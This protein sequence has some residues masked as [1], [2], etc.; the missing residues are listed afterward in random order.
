MPKKPLQPLEDRGPLRI[1]FALTSMPVGGAETLLMNLTQKFNRDRILPEICC[2]KEPG[3]L[4][5]KIKKDLPVHCN[6][7]R[8]KYDVTVAWKLARLFKQR[9]I[10][11]LVTVGAGDKM[12]WGRIAAKIAK[13]PVIACALHSTGWPDGVGRLNR[14]LT[15][16]TD[17]FIAVAKD[18]KRF[19]VEHERFPE[20]RI[21]FIPNGVDTE[22]FQDVSAFHDVRAEFGI[23]AAAP[24]VGLVAALRPEKNLTLFLDMAK[25]VS[26]HIPESHFLL[27]G[28]GPERTKLEQ[29]AKAIGVEKNVHF[30]GTRSDIPSILS[31]MNVFAL[32]SHNEANPVSILEAMST[33]LPIVATNVGSI[34]ESVAHEKTGFLVTP[35]CC[36]ELAGRVLNFL[37]NPVK[38]KAFGDRGRKV[39]QES[40]SLAAMVEGYEDLLTEIYSKKVGCGIKA[41]APKKQKTPTCDQVQPINR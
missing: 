41:K 23:P 21:H 35:G 12:F 6:F 38:A 36:D 3:E 13:V 10:D 8:S 24:V 11:G 22:R 16:M 19:L 37:Q 29:H 9:R 5:E 17:A 34:H 4:G 20:D 7:I 27:V 39:V 15:P 25:Q 30:C 1:M 33:G 32:T 26:Q 14:L 18:H 2:L 40:W 28:D 31:A